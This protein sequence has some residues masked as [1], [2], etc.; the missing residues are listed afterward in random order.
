MYLELRLILAILTCYRLARMIAM[1]DGPGYIFESLRD[2]AQGK[3]NKEKEPAGK[4]HNLAE[5]LGCPYCAGVWVSLP[6]LALL[7]WPTVV[8]DW[9]MVLLSISGGQ[10]FMQ[11][12]DRGK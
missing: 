1:D 7:L 10:A 6:L 2:W 8:G 5:G 11:T 3:A 9:F 12:Q 4:W